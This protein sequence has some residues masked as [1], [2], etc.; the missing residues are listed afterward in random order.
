MDV[1]GCRNFVE[2]ESWERNFVC[3]RAK[4]GTDLFNFFNTG[5]KIKSML[6]Q[7]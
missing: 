2:K 4:M 5:F 6:V 3:A 7:N 1:K